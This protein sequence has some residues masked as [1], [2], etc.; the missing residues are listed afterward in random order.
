MGKAASYWR[1]KLKPSSPLFRAAGSALLESSKPEDLSAAGEVFSSLRDQDPTDRVAIAG[2]VASYATTDYTRISSDLDK[3]TPVSRLISGIDAAALEE[4]GVP[5]LSA[6]TAAGSKKRSAEVEKEKPAKKRNI[7]KS[8]MPK[9]FE[10]GKKM[11]PERWLPLR[12]RSSYRPKGKKG[13]KKAMDLTQGGIAK[14]E[15]SLE[16]AGGAGT[17]KVEKSSNK[18]RGGGKPKKKPG[19]K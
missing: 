16:L 11:D 9:D 13:K 3:L 12:D 17:V 5:H 6:P 14:D 8:R 10:E 15:E 2:L 19:K 7:R 18:S 4:A 1:Q